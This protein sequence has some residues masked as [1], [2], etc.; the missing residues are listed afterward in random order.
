MA[1]EQILIV[2][3]YGKVGGRISELLCKK[4]PGKVIAAG[5]SLD[6]AEAF[7]RKLEGKVIPM[8]LDVNK[9]IDERFFESVKLVVMC[10]D[11]TD[12]EFV[13]T[14]LMTGT[15]YIDISANYDFLSSIEALDEAAK[16]A[17]VSAV[18]SVGLAPGLTNL[19]A[20]EAVRKMDSCDEIQITVMLGLGEKHGRAAIEWTVDQMNTRFTVQENGKMREVNSL[21]DG[22]KVNFHGELGRHKAFRY[23]FAD[24]HTLP[25]TL[26]IPSVS[27]RLCFDSRAATKGTALMKSAGILQLLR[28]PLI[29]KAAVELLSR[30][31]L[32]SEIFAVKVDGYGL[33]E[34]KHMKVEI[35]LEGSQE[36]LITADTAAA[37]AD[38]LYHRDHPAGV[39]HIEQVF[40][41]NDLIQA[42]EDPPQLKVWINGQRMS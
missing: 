1:K 25:R 22:L 29:K 26:G 18:L 37:A 5:K 10:L 17:S 41:I 38:A 24:Q 20:Q 31:Q 14:C 23:H 42:M 34:D 7:S 30:V 35:L 21:S 36:S 15:A 8:A 3:G 6:K 19:M 9:R 28:V 16:T 4:Y 27:T 12:T 39:Y 40:Q 2:G 32:G 33:A 13:K 11:Q